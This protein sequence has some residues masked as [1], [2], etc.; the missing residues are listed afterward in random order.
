MPTLLWLSALLR[1]MV[2]LLPRT[3]RNAD[4]VSAANTE[5]FVRKLSE[6]LSDNELSGTV[7]GDWASETAGYDF[8]HSSLSED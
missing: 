3:R 7:E 6:L 5:E 1:S 2:P 4:F 8:G